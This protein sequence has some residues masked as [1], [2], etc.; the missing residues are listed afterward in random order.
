MIR[1]IERIARYIAAHADEPLPLARLAREA[2][3]S[4]T[5]LQRRFRALVGVSP[6]EFQ[7]SI[8]LGVLKSKLATGQRV[9]DAIGS[10]G[11][12]STSRVYATRARS[13]GMSPSRY[14][15]GGAG[16]AISYAVRPT[17][18][19]TLMMAATDQGV[20][21]ASFGPDAASLERELRGEFPRAQIT[22]SDA[23]GSSALAA[24]I[25]ALEAYLEHDAPCP[26]LPLDL[27]GT[28]FQI[29][30]WRFLVGMKHGTRAT[31]TE[32]ARGIGAPAAVSA[33]ASACGAN[34]IAVLVPCHRILRGDGGLGGYRWGIERKQALLEQEAGAPR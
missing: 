22:P 8:R 25:D 10:A 12:E 11:F 20:C 24:W 15:A 4:P 2:G 31:Y 23:A 30:V 16:E 7:D 34:R 29:K 18:L 6:R 28:A 26:D 13:L 27:R 3:I 1:R 33:A 9:I 21:F 5:Y 32:L 19:G 17:R 14:R